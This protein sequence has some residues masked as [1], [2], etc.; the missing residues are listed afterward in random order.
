MQKTLRTTLRAAFV[1]LVIAA[2]ANAAQAEDAAKPAA[3]TGPVRVAT[4]LPFVEDA[5]RAQDPARVKVVA[6]VRRQMTQAPADDVAD[7]GSPHDPSFER[8]AAAKPTLVVGDRALHG[9]FAPRFQES[10]LAILLI[11]SMSVEGTLSGLVEVAKRCGVDAAMTREVDAARQAL[12]GTAPARR[13]LLVFGTPESFTL[14]TAKTW[15]GDLAARVGLKNLATEVGGPERHPGFVEVSDEVLAGMN[16]ELVLLVSHGAPAQ[17]RER[18]AERFQERGIW[19]KGTSPAR[20]HV[21]SPAL[22]ASNP[23]LQLGAA[24]GELRKLATDP[25]TA[26]GPA[27]GEPRT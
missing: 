18:F 3:S 25:E 21:L 9:R 10:G 5:L 19:Q 17:V 26:R 7:L 27:E 16:P 6:T 12:T 14:M 4:L 22:F 20:I 24:A 1:A 13:T 23:G 15:V 11:D 2:V 8:L